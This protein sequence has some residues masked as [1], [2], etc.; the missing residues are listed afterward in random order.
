VSAVALRRLSLLDASGRPLVADLDL[1]V[2]PGEAVVISAPPELGTA[3]LRAIVG[4]ERPASGEA[5]LLGEEVR[6]LPSARAEAL[7]ARVGYLPRHGA[8]VSNLPIREN[9]VLPFLWH[10]H[11]TRADALEGARRAAGRFG[12]EGLP[13]IIPPLASVAIRRRMA[14]ARATA[15]GPEVLLLDD[16]TEDLDPRTSGDVAGR[17]AET[18]RALGAAVLA[19]SHE[20]DVPMA[21]SARVLTLTPASHP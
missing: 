20:S 13:A 19:T 18:A 17:L 12:V 4:L 7:L 8:L 6:S 10:R 3:I 11:M 2:A 16:P 14:L 5:R 9:L 1:E 15:L 21:L